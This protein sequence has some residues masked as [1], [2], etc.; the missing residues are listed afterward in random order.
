MRKFLKIV[1]IFIVLVCIAGIGFF[2]YLRNLMYEKPNNFETKEIGLLAPIHSDK[3]TWKIGNNYLSLVDSGMYVMYIE[4]DPMQ[5]GEA[6]GALTRDLHRQQEDYFIE[7]IKRM[8]PDKY[9]LRFLKYFISWF[10]RDIENYIPQEYLQEI[11][12]ES[13]YM[14]SDYDQLIGPPYM[15]ILNYHAAHDIGHALQ[16]KNFVAGCTSFSAWGHNTNDGKVLIGRNFDFYV[17]DDFARNKI[18]C[19]M[20]PDKGIPFAMVTWPGMIGAVSG[21]NQAGISVT[22][23]AAKSA[24]PTEAKTPVSIV[25]REILQYAHTIEEAYKIAAQ[26][27]MFVSES[28]LVGS[29]GEN[30][31]AII[32]KS[33]DTLAIFEAVSERIVCANHFQSELLKN[34]K[35]NADFRTNSSSAYRYFRLNELLDTAGVLDVQKVVKILRNPYGVKNEKI[36]W[37]N[38]KA[39]NQLIAHHSI[40]IRPGIPDFWVSTNPWQLGKYLHFDLNKVFI[41]NEFPIDL[42]TTIP[43]DTLLMHSVYPDFIKYKNIRS[44]IHAGKKLSDDELK[45]LVVVNPDFYETYELLG[46]YY[47]NITMNKKAGIQY[48]LALSKV[49]PTQKDSMRLIKKLNKLK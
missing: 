4:G 8:I 31:A 24:I 34:N 36:G 1:L 18:I 12:Y 9:Y 17:G 37:G 25:C 13:I 35:N 48:K 19:F 10:T 47:Y 20:K 43:E 49:I 42:S 38:E 16:D 46:D 30:K 26:R 28:I 7:Q 41:K 11:Y 45:A 23:N 39:M 40:I 21:V 5:R 6:I 22:I 2:Y 14:H 15:R 32:E 29:G 27:H 44:K 33:P 3:S